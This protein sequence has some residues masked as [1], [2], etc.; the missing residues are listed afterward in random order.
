M[1]LIRLVQ[2]SCQ[3]IPSTAT[4]NGSNHIVA[5]LICLDVWTPLSAGAQ[6]HQ[7]TEGDYTLRSST[8]GSETI[9]ASVAK[10]HGFEQKPSVSIL[11]VTVIEKG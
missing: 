11:N 4:M 3:R 5:A 8:V 2:Q 6:S 7:V 1:T 9:P 10:V